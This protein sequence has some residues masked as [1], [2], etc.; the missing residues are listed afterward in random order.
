MP[1][2]PANLS[3]FE[4]SMTR[5]FGQESASGPAKGASKMYA[6]TKNSCSNG[7]VHSG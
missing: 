6:P 7:S 5:P 4:S 2:A 3:P 1:S